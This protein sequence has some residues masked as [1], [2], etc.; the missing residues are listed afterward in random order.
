MNNYIDELAEIQ[1]TIDFN[2][3]EEESEEPREHVDGMY[4]IILQIRL[5]FTIMMKR[6]KMSTSKCKKKMR[7]TSRTKTK[8][9]KTKMKRNMK[10]ETKFI[11]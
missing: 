10:V 5:K 1:K 2:D 9:M 4:I 11:V 3:L 7:T 6:R 8:K